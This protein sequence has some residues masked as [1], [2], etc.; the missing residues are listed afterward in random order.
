MI[1]RKP[2][3]PA[4]NE[5]RTGVPPHSMETITSRKNSRVQ[6]LRRLGREKAYRR[7]T[8]LFLCDGAKLLSEAVMNGAEIAEIYLRGNTPAAALPDAPV[9]AL[10][11]EVFD[12]VSPLEHSPGPLFTVK[13]RPFPETARPDR[14]IVL[15][16]VQDPGNVG[17]VLRTAAALGTELVVLLGDCADPYNPKTVRAAM[18]ALF[19][20][21]IWE[22]DP[23]SLRARLREWSLPLCGAALRPESEDVRHVSLARAAIAVGNEGRGLSEAL[24]DICDAKI[25]L[26]MTPGSE[27]LNAAVAAS[28]LMWEMWTQRKE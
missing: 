28:I 5:E 20:E 24:L 13:N 26:P 3:V 17:T 16:N 19:R 18:G 22:T 11:E 1:K 27:S 8:G 7:E 2:A 23:D 4:G 15:E 10:S 12:Y 25:I 21:R 14:V 9:Y 6:M